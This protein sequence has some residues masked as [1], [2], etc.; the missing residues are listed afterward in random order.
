MLTQDETLTLN[1]A[2]MEDLNTWKARMILPHFLPNKCK[3][4][5]RNV[6]NDKYLTEYWVKFVYKRVNAGKG[7]NTKI[8][9]QEMKQEKLVETE[10]ENIYQNTI[11]IDASKKRK[12]P[13]QIE[14]WSILSDHVK[15]I[16]HDGSETFHNLNINALNYCQN[17]DLY[18]ELKEKE[19]LKTNVAF[20]RSPKKLRS[21]YLDV[22]EGVYTEVISTDRFDEDT[23][24]S[25]TYPGQVNMSRDTE[26]RAE[27][28]FPITARGHTRG[29][30]L[31]GTDCEILIDTGINKSYMSKSYFMQYESLH[32]MPK[33]TSSTRRIQVGNGQYVGV[34]FVI[35]VIVTIHKHSF[36]IFT[37]VS[38]IHGNVDLVLGIKN[39]FE[40]EG[41]ID[42]WDSCLSFSDR[43]N[44][45]SQGNS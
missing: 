14:E 18:K 15:Y 30:L 33:F 25:T 21:D 22:Y 6:K 20:G 43:S 5:E 37:L 40:L 16:K 42:S 13:T 11:L 1:Y 7:I 32:A 28:S 44:Y 39:L 17:K 19:M 8:I 29:E 3:R 41:V 45:F 26:V 9:Q 31:D 27:E 2:E 24:V 34:L 35:P 36:E 4:G 38:E 12:A 23:D 10:I